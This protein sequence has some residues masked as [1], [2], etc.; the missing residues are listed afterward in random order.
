VSAILPAVIGMRG[1]R[2]NNPQDIDI[3]VPLRRT[4]A[5]VGVPGSGKTSLAIGTLHAEGMHRFLEGLTTY[6]RRQLSSLIQPSRC[7]STAIPASVYSAPNRRQQAQAQGNPGRQ[8]RCG[9]VKS[10]ALAIR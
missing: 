2:H 9:A 10:R 6:S 3:D 7:S 4:V 5:V 8:F 1:A